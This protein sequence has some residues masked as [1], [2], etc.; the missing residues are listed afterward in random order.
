MVTKSRYLLF[1]IFVLRALCSGE[2]VLPKS[3]TP[4]WEKKV[5]GVRHG[6]ITLDQAVEEK[7]QGYL[8]WRFDKRLIERIKAYVEKHPTGVYEEYWANKQIKVRLPYKKKMPHGHIHGWFINGESAFKGHFENGNKLGYHITFISPKYPKNIGKCF[9]YSQSGFLEG[10]QDLYYKSGKLWV[11]CDYKNG[12]AHGALEGWD[13]NGKEFLA[14]QYKKGVLQKKPPPPPGLRDRSSPLL[15]ERYVNEVTRNFILWATKE[16]DIAP[17]GVGAGMPYDVE[18]I[19]VSFTVGHRGTKE[20]GRELIVKLR[21][22]LVEMVNAHEKLRPY[23]R[24]YPFTPIRADVSLIFTD[25]KGFRTNDGT[26]SDVIVND[27]NEICYLSYKNPRENHKVTER[28]EEA[29][30]IVFGEGR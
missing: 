13:E 26:I 24:E 10:S 15:D 6:P 23:L 7:I 3:I 18:S 25:A 1:F 5:L 12:K 19:I 16:Y 17:Y 14:A 22:R 2:I 8:E 28:Y 27:K 9:L 30:K 21:K 20:E 4:E 29:V 11:S